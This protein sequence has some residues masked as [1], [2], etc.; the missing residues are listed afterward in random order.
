[1]GLCHWKDKAF[2]T[3]KH[4]KKIR[5]GCIESES[6]ELQAEIQANALK[7]LHELEKLNS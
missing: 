5:Q 3:E 1:M 6:N 2:Q 7:H 4:N